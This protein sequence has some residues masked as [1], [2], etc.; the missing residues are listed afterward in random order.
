[1]VAD[2]DRDL[3]L[4]VLIGD[5][6]GTIYC[7]EA[8]ACQVGQVDWPM[9]RGNV[10]QTG[11][12][13]PYGKA[14]V[15]LSPDI[16]DTPEPWVK[17]VEPGEVM[18]YHLN[19][20]NTGLGAMS[21]D[22][23]TVD[24]NPPSPPGSGW[25]ASIGEGLD[26]DAHGARYAE[27]EPGEGKSFVVRVSVPDEAPVGDI[28]IFTVNATSTIDPGVRDSI[29]LVARLNYSF[30]IGLEF[31]E[32]A[33]LTDEPEHPYNDEK[34]AL[35]TPGEEYTAVARLRNLGYL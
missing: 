27:L 29:Q 10:N 32:P 20:K 33:L 24:V 30:G 8:G 28:A 2:I 26:T 17:E 23:I 14:G 12:Y 31:T 22:T 16:P 7:I 21:V 3:I 11:F 5:I 9:F 18:E 1:M 25:S 6:D 19:V 15:A 34:W 13:R 4:E 35:I